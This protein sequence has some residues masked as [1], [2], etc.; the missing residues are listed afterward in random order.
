MRFTVPSL[1]ELQAK[2]AS[3]LKRFPLSVTVSFGLFVT[4]FI[5][6]EHE[7]D[8]IW[9][10]T[11]FA[12]A[13]ALPLSVAWHIAAEQ[14]ISRLVKTAWA[15]LLLLLQ[16]FYIYA[17]WNEAFRN[18]QFFIRFWPLFF[19]AHLFVAFAPFLTRETAWGQ[20]SRQVTESLF[21]EYNKT[22]FLRSLITALYSGVLYVGL[23]IAILALTKLFDLEIKGFRYAQLFFAILSIFN[24]IFFLSGVPRAEQIALKESAE[25][26]YPIGLK[27]FTQFVLLPLVALYLLILY[28]YLA[29]IIILF[30][31]PKGWVSWLVISYAT[32]SIFTLLLLYPIRN[33][34]EN[35][36][37]PIFSRWFYVA[38]F[39][40]I[41]LQLL[42]IGLRLNQYGLTEKR[43]IILVLSLWLLFIALHYTLR[44]KRF[45]INHNGDLGIRFIPVSLSIAVVLIAFLAIP[46]S[47]QSQWGRL[48]SL[49]S[50]NGLLLNGELQFILPERDQSISERDRRELF[51]TVSYLRSYHSLSAISE[52]IP[53]EKKATF[54]EVGIS[55][56][57]K[58]WDDGQ[59]SIL[60]SLGVS[61]TPSMNGFFY[62]DFFS[63]IPRIPLK[64]YQ[65]GIFLRDTFEQEFG[66]D[67]IPR[68]RFKAQLPDTSVSI[69]I[70]NSDLLFFHTSTQSV[71][72]DS[73]I[74][75]YSLLPF[76]EKY[77][78]QSRTTTKSFET[79]SSQLIY[80]PEVKCMEMMLFIESLNG[81]RLSVERLSNSA[82]NAQSAM[83]DISEEESP[84]FQGERS[85]S[86]NPSVREIIRI[87]SLKGIL[88]LKPHLSKEGKT[89]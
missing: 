80:L 54:A 33:N 60:E 59:S 64:G 46:M 15:T 49:M 57:Q 3:T 25:S 20:D 67:S 31:L 26:P 36:W 85:A 11:C 53:K 48:K 51:E 66:K 61:P 62:F 9:I 21:W 32:A 38:L 74:L 14:L 56:D 83:T 22:L 84:I 13:I 29:K 68:F 78:V 8:K 79:D 23:S 7:P 65:E 72:G 6:I 5:A 17:I 73:L 41:G 47:Y 30:S 44:L 63:S 71:T 69:A 27:R 70:E 28:A 19:A 52:F 43:F 39:P 24:T 42:S 2:A 75:R 37:I 40:L 55:S 89:L 1:E 45:S 16:G 12:F 82:R 34:T 77:A 87:Q 50:A 81:N 86:N 35:K 76:I 10:R 58:E 88:F 18:E 4:T